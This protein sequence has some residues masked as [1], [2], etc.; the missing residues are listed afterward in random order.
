MPNLL[1]PV[2]HRR[3]RTS[4]A[5]GVTAL[6]IGSGAAMAQSP[7]P[8]YTRT[9]DSLVEVRRQAPY[10]GVYGL[11]AGESLRITPDGEL[12]APNQS[13]GASIGLAGRVLNEGKLRA[14]FGTETMGLQV[15]GELTNAGGS[16]SAPS[17]L[18]EA[19]LFMAYPGARISNFGAMYTGSYTFPVGPS[20][21]VAQRAAFQNQGAALA[22]TGFA[23]AEG[24]QVVNEF[25]GLWF[26]ESNGG[27]LGT[28]RNEGL[29]FS[30]RAPTT[31]PA[32]PDGSNYF[33]ILQ[34]GMDWSSSPI[35]R[36]DNQGQMFLDE[37]TLLR[38]AGTVSNRLLFASAGPIEVQRNGTLHNEMGG[39]MVLGGQVTVSPYV[40]YDG[41]L[42]NFGNLTLQ[43][44]GQVRNDGRV[45]NGFGGVFTIAA[46]VPGPG[47]GVL[48][49]AGS[50]VQS[51]TGTLENRGLLVLGGSLR[52]GFVDNL[53]G[54]VEV[55]PAG[56]LAVPAF[57]G[58][59][60]ANAGG[61]IE[62]GRDAIMSVEGL[63][64][65]SGRL[66]VNGMLEIAPGGEL[67]VLGGVLDGGG[68][69]DR[70]SGFVTGGGVINGN[71]FLSGPGGGP[72]QQPP[73]CFATSWACFRPGN[74]PGAV[75]ISGDLTLGENAVLQ[76]EIERDAQG[77]LH[78]DTVLA[79]TMHFGAGSVIELMLGS[80]VDTTA[81]LPLD[82]LRCDEG[83]TFEGS[84]RVLGGSGQ[85][86]ADGKGLQFSG[87][88]AVSEPAPAALL[89]AGALS[90]AWLRRRRSSPTQ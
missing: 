36:I 60:V 69:L 65:T 12:N 22:D 64:Q 80:G 44:G 20:F 17:G 73:F 89:L 8:A 43:R 21:P 61:H 29:F 39:E 7:P 49:E 25:G 37:L 59:Q 84:F 79:T 27:V 41:G 4:V 53:G 14:A 19:V 87:V 34:V 55:G 67:R 86:L 30:Q 31:L 70:L 52:G 15:S 11:P 6:L 38:S 78:W 5:Q 82:L 68:T 2:S 75:Q 71:L 24:A 74:S 85:F 42:R 1:R 45:L 40:P 88:S 46:A 57:Y 32:S 77:V 16:L 26:S 62:V 35:G 9:I 90:L 47:G 81:G 56:H 54:R 66:T 83:C 63:T 50:I 58:G 13:T 3:L 76:L 48:Y 28:L 72:L 33:K 23:I 18:I 10:F 51:E